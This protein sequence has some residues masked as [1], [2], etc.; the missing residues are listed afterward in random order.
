MMRL[1]GSKLLLLGTAAILL[2]GCGGGG[3]GGSGDETDPPQAVN[4]TATTQEDTPVTI[5]VTANDTLTDSDE[6]ID[7]TSVAI[8]TQPAHGSAAVQTDG[9]GSV[10]Y[11]PDANYYGSD[12]F[13]YTVK[14]NEGEESNV[15]TV[16]ITVTAVSDGPPVAVDDSATTNEGSSVTID[17]TA[18]DTDPDGNS[19]ID[20]STVTITQPANGSATVNATTGV[21]TY[22]PN[23]GFNGTDSFTYTVKDDTGAAS[24]SATVTITVNAVDSGGPAAADD[25][26]STLEDTLVNIDVT[27]NDTDPDGANTIDKTSIAVQTAPGNGTATPKA[28]GTIDYTPN[29][30]FF[31]TDTFTYTVKD[32]AGNV[33]NPATVTVSVTAVASGSNWDEAQWDKG[34]WAP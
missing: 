17:V 1:Y 8:K 3:G 34:H 7:K 2:G 5:D 31:G 20:K 33:S 6:T 14:D 29:T 9:S 4:D 13:T 25:T 23:A 22:T 21:V 18:N 16:A 11:T 32:D 26:A 10:V 15:A 24:N 30:G 19:T 12:S 28:D 27:A